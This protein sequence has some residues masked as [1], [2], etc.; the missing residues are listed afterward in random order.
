MGEREPWF[1]EAFRSDYVLVYAHRD[2]HSARREAKYLVAQ[3]VKGRVLDLC[4]GFG[5]H[6]VAL[7]ERGVDAF[8]IDLSREL[9]DQARIL[10][11]AEA[12]V[13]RLLRADARRFPVR[14]ASLDGVVSLFSSFGY[15]GDE[16][17]RAVLAEIARVLRKGGLAVL[18]L[19]NPPQVR[20]KLV[21]ESRRNVGGFD[22]AESRALADGE[23]R[24]TKTVR[25]SR[26]PAKERVWREEVRMY[27]PEEIAALLDRAGL[28][29]A[30]AHGD[31][32]A[33]P[34]SPASPR[35]IVIARRR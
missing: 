33:S 35:Q 30:R 34:L 6:I 28:E 11:E 3:G 15:F 14:D 21:L 18:D 10:P 26:P 4:C 31:F 7:R 12:L 2:L 16:G 20:A 32:D 17:D 29:P 27:E 23:K 5:R 1:V 8:G 9:L 13:G 19:M 24:V 25:I 22:V